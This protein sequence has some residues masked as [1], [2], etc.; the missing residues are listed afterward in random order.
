M[1]KQKIVSN[2][3]YDAFERELTMHLKEG[4][5]VVPTT[6]AMFPVNGYFFVVVEKETDEK[7]T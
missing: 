6:L 4:W 3:T 5:T 1:K 2:F 7:E